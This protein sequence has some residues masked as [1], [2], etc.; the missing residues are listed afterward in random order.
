[1][2]SRKKTLFVNLLNIKDPTM[3]TLCCP[4]VQTATGQH[5]NPLILIILIIL[6]IDSGGRYSYV[7][8]SNNNDL[9]ANTNILT[10]LIRIANVLFEEHM[11]QAG[12]FT[13]EKETCHFSLLCNSDTVFKLLQTYLW[14]CN[15]SCYF[16][17]TDAKT[18]AIS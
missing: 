2:Y 6:I 14:Y 8:F 9:L 18:P 4:T 11:H 13:V 10:I 16:L 5:N 3:R 1:M 7:R 15:F 17:A 12:H